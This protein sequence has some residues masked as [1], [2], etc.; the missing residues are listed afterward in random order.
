MR[1]LRKKLKLL[2]PVNINISRV[3]F[4]LPDDEV[5]LLGAR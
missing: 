1:R 2:K 5:D 3:E 4:L